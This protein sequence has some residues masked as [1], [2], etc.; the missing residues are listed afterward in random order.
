MRQWCVVSTLSL[1]F[2]TT[3]AIAQSN[4]DEDLSVIKG[5]VNKLTKPNAEVSLRVEGVTGELK[6]N[7]EAYIGT[8]SE[9][10]LSDW[11]AT[12]PRLRKLAREALE[13]VGYYQSEVQFSRQEK[14]VIVKVT[15]N[16]PVYV[17]KLS[18][19]YQGEASNDIAFT[20]LLDILPLR[21]G[22]ILHHG[23]YENIKTLVQNMALERG[24][25]DGRWQKNEV[26]VVQPAQTAEINLDYD[27]GLR[28]K[29]GELSFHNKHDNQPLPVKLELLEKL[30][31]FS[32][33]EPYEAEKI[34]KFNKTLLDSRYFNEVRVRAEPELAVN[35]EIPVSVTLAA[36]KPNQLDVGAG[37]ATDIGA[38]LSLVW[39]RPLFNDRGHSIE[40]TTEISQ[41]RQSIDF[42]YGIPWALLMTLYN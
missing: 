38:R 39:R 25:F 5:Y 33:G 37:Y 13:A 35:Q 16:Q 10:D 31:S 28:Y 3:T 27:S 26:V 7:I 15:P 34:I 21:E 2:L 22:D 24:Y 1:F 29:F 6:T 40:T 19:R 4:D 12:V 20:A 11:R 9:D 17:R 23:R 36:D 32:Q 14:Q 18:L 30:S 42:R 8:L 41:V